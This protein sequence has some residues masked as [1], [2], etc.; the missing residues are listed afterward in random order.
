M[1]CIK[2]STILV[3]CQAQIKQEISIDM[4]L[5][6]YRNLVF[7]YLIKSVSSMRNK[8]NFQNSD[9]LAINH[10]FSVTNRK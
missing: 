8:R 4:E 2:P 7:V 3:C 10:F 5:S 1:M 6:L 9:I